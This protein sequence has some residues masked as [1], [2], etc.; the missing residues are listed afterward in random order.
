MMTL[1]ALP[2]VVSFVLS[3]CASNPG[4]TATPSLGTTSAPSTTAPATT[5]PTTPP[6]SSPDVNPSPSP[7]STPSPP[8]PTPTA[9][10]SSDP[11]GD[12]PPPLATLRLPDGTSVVGKLGSWCSGSSCS[13][14][15]PYPI[16]RLP[17]IHLKQA[18]GQLEIIL[19][20]GKRFASWRASYSESIV[21]DSYGITLGS[22][23]DPEAASDELETA[24]FAGPPAGSWGLILTLTFADPAGDAFYSWHAVVGG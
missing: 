6:I 8:E 20:E 13:D 24:S 7:D 3:A 2:I 21:D 9:T 4:A 12:G 19:E 15:P 1:R 5:A 14:T 18:G 22:G 11:A 16:N 23:G 17:K 10:T